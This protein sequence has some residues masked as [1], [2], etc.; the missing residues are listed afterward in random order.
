MGELS[1][2][3]GHGGAG[4]AI[5]LP[6]VAEKTRRNGED[7]MITAIFIPI[8]FIILMLIRHQLVKAKDFERLFDERQRRIWAEA[9]RLTLSGLLVWSSLLWLWTWLQDIPLSLT[10]FYM[11]SLVVG[12]SL[13]QGYRIWKGA[14]FGWKAK[15]KWA[16]EV[17]SY[18]I[19]GNLFI[20]QLITNQARQE[21]DW[22][23]YLIQGDGAIWCG[24]ALMFTILFV[25]C[26][27]KWIWEKGHGVEEEL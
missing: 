27:V 16:G 25:V 2:F 18:L 9:N 23:A 4:H 10:A 19:L 7:L 12:A 11:S 3:W 20:W 14:Y 17:V 13:Q 21:L 8:A 22:T 26:L 1:G 5:F 6:Q 15:N 24:G